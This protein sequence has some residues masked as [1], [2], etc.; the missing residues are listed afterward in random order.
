MALPNGWD[1][2]RSTMTGWSVVWTRGDGCAELATALAAGEPRLADSDLRAA[3]VR[4]RADLLVARRLT[5]FDLVGTV[6]PIGFD[7]ESVGSVVAAVGGG[8][9]SVL[10]ARVTERLAAV[11]GVDGSLVSAS[12]GSGGDAPAERA[13]AGLAHVVSGLPGRVVHVESA[14]AL[15]DELPSDAL[16]V[17]GAPG[18]SWLQR[19]FFG[20]GKQLIVGAPGGALVVRSAPERCFQRMSDPDPIGARML[21]GDV[22]RLMAGPVAPVVD[23][24]VLV[25]IVRRAD[26]EGVDP[27]SPVLPHV[28]DPVFVSI[29]DPVESAAEL[30]EFL[31]HGPVP[32]VDAE[33]RLVG[34]V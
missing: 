4:A 30:M 27:G 32:V 10:A 23:D 31:D 28:E 11:L 1:R 8:P 22:L 12:A 14:R 13:L 20:P 18:G 3:C 7:A 24:G 25:G 2:T 21:V 33:G 6:V 15:V 29:D 26:I 16:L 9:H 17:V 19:Q 34:V 5:S